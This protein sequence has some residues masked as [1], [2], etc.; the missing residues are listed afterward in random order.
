MIT[1]DS[2]RDLLKYG[3]KLTLECKKAESHVPNSV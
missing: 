1:A 3:E 2:L